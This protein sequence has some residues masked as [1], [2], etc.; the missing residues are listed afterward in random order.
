LAR[1]EIG[2]SSC[3]FRD[4]SRPVLYNT[5]GVVPSLLVGNLHT[6]QLDLFDNVPVIVHIEILAKPSHNVKRIPAVSGFLRDFSDINHLLTI[7]SV[8]LTGI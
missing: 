8:N 2:L 7:E 3:L 4:I 6:R 5:D 1:N